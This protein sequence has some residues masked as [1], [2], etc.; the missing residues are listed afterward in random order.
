VKT[1]GK[2]KKSLITRRKS[3]ISLLNSAA[4]GKKNAVTQVNFHLYHYAGNNPIRYTDPD[5]RLTAIVMARA[6]LLTVGLFSIYY[7]NAP[8]GS[9]NIFQLS[10]PNAKVVNLE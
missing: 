1:A 3:R 10:N 9:W 7:F 5:G 2:I 6:D 8:N 4:I